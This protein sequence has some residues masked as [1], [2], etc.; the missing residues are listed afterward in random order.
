MSTI[1]P[2]TLSDSCANATSRL[3]ISSIFALSSSEMRLLTP[4][5]RPKTGC[6]CLPPTAWMIQWFSLRVLSTCPARS[7][8]TLAMT[9]SM[10]RC[11]DRGV[12]AHDEIGPAQDIKMR[13]MVG[14]IK[15]AVK[16]LAYLFGGAGR[17]GM[18]HIVQRLGG[19]HVVRFGA[20]AADALGDLGHILDRAAFA[21]LLEAAQLGYL[22]VDVGH[23][24]VV[25]EED[26]Y[27]A[28]SFQPGDGVDGYLF[29]GLILA[30]LIMESA[31]AVAV[32]CAGGVDDAVQYLLDL[33]RIVGVD[34]RGP[35]R[36]EM[37]LP[38]S[39]TPSTGP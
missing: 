10:L 7:M 19:G 18:E 32:A 15:G 5:G 28:V 16:Q 21:E 9:P 2:K 22:Q 13:G 3:A 27:L 36:Q 34:D 38:W 39:R 30:L 23:A 33:I 4:P 17:L 29:H 35:G 25:I 14:D 26:G 37:W 24:A 6:I 8:P 31:Q 11:A 20:D 12:G 1:S